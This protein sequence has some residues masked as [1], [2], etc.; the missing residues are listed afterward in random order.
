[1]PKLGTS[2]KLPKSASVQNKH[3]ALPGGDTG[4]RN[5]KSSPTPKRD[6]KTKTGDPTTK[7][8]QRV[9]VPLKVNKATSRPM[10]SAA[11]AQRK[12]PPPVPRPA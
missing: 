11:G 12:G 5:M 3:N 1:M 4:V 2:N 7:N 9:N 10:V 6:Q 8:G